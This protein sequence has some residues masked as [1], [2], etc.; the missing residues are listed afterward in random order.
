M[1]F[2]CTQKT[3]NVL[4]EDQKKK[5]KG[6]IQSVISRI[7][8]AAAHVDTTKLF[9]V[10][11]FSDKDFVYIETTGAFYDSSAYKQMVL[12]FYG[13]LTSEMIARG[14]EKYTYLDEDNVLWSYS[15]S[16]TATFKNNQRAKYEPF[17]MTMLFRKTNGKWK[18]VFL[19]ESTQES[20]ATKQ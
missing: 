14:S 18:V 17:G 10:F 19:Q 13:L 6:E 15:G 16:L 9:E 2:S 20:Q 12:Q 8:D 1:I 3:K 7:Y 4:N 5:I 11:S